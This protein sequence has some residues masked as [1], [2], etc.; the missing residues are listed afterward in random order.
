MINP[1]ARGIKEGDKVEIIYQQAYSKIIEPYQ[2]YLSKLMDSGARNEV[3]LNA[4]TPIW[5]QQSKIYYELVQERREMDRRETS[6]R[7]RLEV[8]IAAQVRVL[9]KLNDPSIIKLNLENN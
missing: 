1:F 7:K 6:R 5:N 8:K 4:I 3:L 9:E 2:R